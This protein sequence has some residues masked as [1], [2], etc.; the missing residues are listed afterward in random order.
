MPSKK[1]R[2]NHKSKPAAPM[3]SKQAGTPVNAPNQ[4]TV[5]TKATTVP[6]QQPKD[7]NDDAIIIL[8]ATIEKQNIML[9]VL[10]K[11]IM[12]K[13]ETIKMKDKII[14]SSNA[15]NRSS[16]TIMQKNDKNMETDA[17][18]IKKNEILKT[19]EAIIK[20]QYKL[21]RRLEEKL[22]GISRAEG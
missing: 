8:H 7:T 9:G 22:E 2:T 10:E 14:K 17:T 12:A 16:E 1:N 19:K 13:D 15:I 3:P 20:H 21:I 6:K 4:T 11:V 18:Y 5:A